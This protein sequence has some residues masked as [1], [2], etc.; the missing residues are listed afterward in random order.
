[1]GEP[2]IGKTRILEELAGEARQ[3]RQGFH[4]EEVQR[5]QRGR[6]DVPVVVRHP[7]SERGALADLDDVAI[8]T[9]AGALVPLWTVARAEL[10]RSSATVQRADRK[11][12]LRVTADVDA[13]VA[14]ANEIIDGLAT[15]VLPRIVADHPGVGVSLEGQ[16]REQSDFMDLITR[17]AL[18]G[19]LAVY[20]LLA[21]PLR[22]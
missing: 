6:H 10:G 9:P 16:R 7:E 17:G 11:R 14:N 3:V 12:M 4:G 18:L 5:A 19:L 8:R 22:S 15:S 1:M 13:R 20:A 21:I 2:G